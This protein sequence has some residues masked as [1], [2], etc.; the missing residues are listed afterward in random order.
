V[1][2]HNFSS[3]VSYSVDCAAI[4]LIV[5]KRYYVA[6]STLNFISTHSV[7]DYFS[8]LASADLCPVPTDHQLVLKTLALFLSGDISVSELERV[9]DSRLFELLRNP[10]MNQEK[11]VLS[12]IDLYLHETK[13]G[14]RDSAELYALAQ[15][16][17]DKVMHS[18]TG[19]SGITEHTRCEVRGAR[20]VISREFSEER[21]P[22][23]NNTTE[24]KDIS[25]VP[26]I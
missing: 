14:F 17:L 21:N 19:S 3:P 16:I 10:E 7:V 2:I 6:P 4:C 11:K 9:V 5:V 13:E 1:L 24:V 23:A 12:I 15:A 22:A 25:L 20:C 18:R 26:A 8:I